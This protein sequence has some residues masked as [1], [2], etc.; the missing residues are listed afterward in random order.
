MSSLQGRKSQTH[1]QIPHRALCTSSHPPHLS[2]VQLSIT[3]GTKTHQ[4][5]LRFP[6]RWPGALLK[7]STEIPPSI[8]VQTGER[9]QTA[10]HRRLPGSDNSKRS[11]HRRQLF[12]LFRALLTS[13]EK[14]RAPQHPGPCRL[15]APSGEARQA[16][17]HGP[18]PSPRRGAA[19]QMLTHGK[20]AAPKKARGSNPTTTTPPPQ[21]PATRPG[22]QRRRNAGPAAAPQGGRAGS[23]RRSPRPGSLFQGRRRRAR[24]APRVPSASAGP[25]RQSQPRPVRPPPPPPREGP[26]AP[27]HP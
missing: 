18:S 22:R 8:R 25:R 4:Q 17:R 6:Q 19:S 13:R 27:P 15:E 12:F 10:D 2:R 3:K 11:Q 23:G 24:R 21:L 5:Q 16:P 20:A 14:P 26:A 1:T 9:N 7:P